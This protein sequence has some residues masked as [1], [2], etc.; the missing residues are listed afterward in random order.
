MKVYR[1][2]NNNIV[3]A[4]D[5]EG[6]EVVVIGKGIGYKAQKDT[7]IPQSKI[8]KIFTMR[9][10]NE[11]ERLKEILSSLPAEYFKIT[12]RIIS[13]ANKHLKRRLHEGIYITLA[14]HI[15]FT[16]MR[17]REGIN[18]QNVL[19]ADIR[20]FYPQEYA[21][22]KYALELMQKRLEISLPKDEASAI[23]LHIFNAEY[24]ISISDAFHAAQLLNHILEMVSEK[25]GLIINENDYYCDRFITH[26][27]YLAQRIF[28]KV[29]P[30]AGD[31]EFHKFIM[32]RY[33]E[34]YKCVEH[35][36]D[37]IYEAYEYSVSREDVGCLAIH[38]K[39]IG[40]NDSD[41]AQGY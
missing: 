25:T 26:L 3:S 36:A 32:A 9:S 33:P 37:Y 30:P 27:K 13:Y 2:I 34:E 10:K 16:V 23:A 39:R 31:D 11:T 1:P 7:I 40:T 8:D 17:Y 18:F 4:F 12:N 28:K 29:D 5:D 21:I 14:D 19:H 41:S 6:R 22:G 35:I 20:R 38:I 15:N 24:D